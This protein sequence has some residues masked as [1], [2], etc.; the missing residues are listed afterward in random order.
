M[1]RVDPS[2]DDIKSSSLE[3]A[4]AAMRYKTHARIWAHDGAF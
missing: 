2:P 3:N 4:G 1:I